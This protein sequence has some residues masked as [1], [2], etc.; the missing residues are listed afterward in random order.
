ME[1][2]VC[3]SFRVAA[4]ALVNDYMTYAA[5]QCERIHE[6]AAAGVIDALREVCP[7]SLMR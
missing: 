3:T 7:C 1:S 6:P 4:Q 5:R 2:M